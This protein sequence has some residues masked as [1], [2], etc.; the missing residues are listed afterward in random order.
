MEN[1]IR[2]LSKIHTEK[3]TRMI[4]VERNCNNYRPIDGITGVHV[5]AVQITTKDA[6]ANDFTSK[7]G[8]V[9]DSYPKS[10]KRWTCWQPGSGLSSLNGLNTGQWLRW[11]QMMVI[12]LGYLTRRVFVNVSPSITTT[13]LENAS[14][15][16]R[17]TSI[18]WIDHER[19]LIRIPILVKL[20]ESDC[21]TSDDPDTTIAKRSGCF[22]RGWRM[23]VRNEGM[24]WNGM[25]WNGVDVEG[26]DSNGNGMEH[27]PEWIWPWNWILS[28]KQLLS[29]I[30]PAGTN[31][32][33]RACNKLQVLKQTPHKSS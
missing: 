22:E 20:S 17:V 29:V 19:L 8:A 24:E 18:Y 11:L 32:H 2:I 9:N 30:S 14:D 26:M 28:W 1:I 10:P 21:Y 33:D 5:E 12:G 4:A 6:F 16:S 3:C 13:T 25:E 27:R 31:L 7:R 23:D 15:I